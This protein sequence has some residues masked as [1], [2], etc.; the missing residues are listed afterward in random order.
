[1][2]RKEQIKTLREY[3]EWAAANEWEAPIALSD[4]LRE[5]ADMLEKDA[6][7]W[8]SVEDNG[9]PEPGKDKWEE[10]NVCVMRLRFDCYDE[11]YESFVTYARYDE[12]QKLWHLD[13]D[14]VLNAMI[15]SDDCPRYGGCVTHYMP[16]PKPPKED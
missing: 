10:Y 16:M 6:P 1:M 14:E 8:I 15:S 5:A 12:D 2:N 9:L 7:K 3:A 13:G 11:Y 4:H